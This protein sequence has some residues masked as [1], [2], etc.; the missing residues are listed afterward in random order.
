QRV[1]ELC[2][3][4]AMSNVPDFGMQELSHGALGKPPTGPIFSR[5]QRLTSQDFAQ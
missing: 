1:G 5:F 4:V 2:D 3:E